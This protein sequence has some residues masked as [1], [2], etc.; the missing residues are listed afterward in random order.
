M[1]PVLAASLALSL[2]FASQAVG[3]VPTLK[4][5]ESV[6]RIAGAIQSEFYDEAK[7][8]KIAA[9]LRA[10]AGRGT[11]DKLTDP[12]DFAGALT[13]RLRPLDGHFSVTWSPQADA[14][15]AGPAVRRDPAAFAEQDRRANYGFRAV[16]V[17]PGN[18]G[19]VDMRYFADFT[20]EDPAARKAADAALATIAGTDAVIFDLRDNGGG[21]PAMVGYLVGHFVPD[22]AD[23]YNSFKMRGEP[24]ASEKPTVPITVPRRL[25]TPLYVLTSARTGSAAESFAYTL[26]SAGRATIVGEASGGGANPGGPRSVGDGL[27]VFISNGSPTNPITKKNWEGTGVIP[28]VAVA[29][30]QALDRAYALAMTR[31][32]SA[33]MSDAA[34]AENRWVLDSL[35]DPAPRGPADLAP[36]AG[37]YGVYQVSVKDGGLTLRQGRRP[38]TTLKPLDDAGLFFVQGAPLRRVKFEGD[39]LVTLG[40]DGSSSR[41]A[42]A[43]VATP[44]N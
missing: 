21:S 16:E 14:A 38:E 22:G 30:P 17:L 26:Q 42:R 8:A 32:M 11:Y 33:P 6:D 4:P 1:K 27:R 10:E 5:R 24:A 13:A 23:I 28:D 34:K 15:P 20:P 40:P 12:R 43:A 25:N 35:V 19:R 18:V 29:S 3:Q 36:F 9:E 7:G 44:G 2:A 31:L 39:A 37:T 41:F